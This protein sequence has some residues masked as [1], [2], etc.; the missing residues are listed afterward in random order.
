MKG[1][2]D[3]DPAVGRTRTISSRQCGARRKSRLPC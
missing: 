3:A 1:M 2:G